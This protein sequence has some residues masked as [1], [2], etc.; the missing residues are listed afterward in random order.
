MDIKSDQIL[1]YAQ[2]PVVIP[3]AAIL[4]NWLLHVRPVVIRVLI[5]C[6]QA[7]R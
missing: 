4:P 6:F 5:V 2:M 7:L 1:G 3:Y